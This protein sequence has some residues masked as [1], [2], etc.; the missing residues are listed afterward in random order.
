MPALRIILAAFVAGALFS[1]PA[2]AQEDTTPPELLSFSFT[3][4]MIDVTAGPATVTASLRVTDDLAGVS[5]AVVRFQS[6]SGQQG[7]FGSFNE[8]CHRISGDALDG[9]YEGSVPFSQFIEAGNWH[10]VEVE[11]QDRV[12]N[13]RFLD[14]VDLIDLEFNTELQ[15]GVPQISLSDMTVTEGN[16]RTTNA[17]FTVSLSFESMQT[18]TVNYATAA[19][20]ARD[21]SDYLPQSATMTF[22]PGMIAQ[23]VTVPVRGERRVEPDETFFVNLS[24][25]TNASLVDGQG[26]GMIRNDDLG[27]RGP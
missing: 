12:G 27:M 19:G 10:V 5:N 18:V 22:S 6:P 23:T 15:V 21:W 4:T 9:V 24:D 20:T 13:R 1:S 3:P 17:D 8:C 16:V 25:P 14:E 11:L 26:I 2:V 7:T